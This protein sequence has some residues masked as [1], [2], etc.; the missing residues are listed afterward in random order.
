MLIFS[1]FDSNSKAE[2][3]EMIET[4]TEM[5]EAE[6]ELIKAKCLSEAEIIKVIESKLLEA[7]DNFRT[8]NNPCPISESGYV[9][10]NGKCIYLESLKMN[11]TN[12]KQNCL[13][14]MKDYGFGQ[15]FEPKSRSMNDLVADEAN[16]SFGNDSSFIGFNDIAIEQTYVFESNNSPVLSAFSPS[17]HKKHGPSGKSK[18]RWVK[19]DCGV[20]DASNSHK[21]NWAEVECKWKH[22]SIC[23]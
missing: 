17:W 20:L 23:E 18:P 10:V 2:I 6:I 7:Q 15:L 19:G 3:S 4:K 1:D 12:A 11:R 13:S 22:R 16:K 5:M 21:G 8:P 9:T 14:K